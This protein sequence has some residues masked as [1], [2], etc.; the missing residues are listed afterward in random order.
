MGRV[1]IRELREADCDEVRELWRASGIR[2]RPGD[3]DV[4]LVALAT[5]NPGLCLV[6]REGDRMVASAL[7]GFDGRRGWLYHVA[8]HPE[9]RRRGIATRLVRTIEERLRALGCRKLNLIVWDEEDDAMAFW[10]AIGY[11]RERTVEFAKEL[12]D[13]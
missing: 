12:A 7:A 3:D 6:G 11:R 5:R 13:S 1:E 10:A 4:G 2:I 9:S 8:T